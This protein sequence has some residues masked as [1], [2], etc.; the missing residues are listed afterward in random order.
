MDPRNSI[1]ASDVFQFQSLSSTAY[2]RSAL[3]KMVGGTFLNYP[4]CVDAVIESSIENTISPYHILSRILQE[5]G[6]SGSTLSSG[7]GYMVNGELKYV[8][9][10]NVFNIGATGNTQKDI[11]INGLSRAEKEGWNSL[12][13]SIIGGSKFLGSNYID[14]GQNTLYFQKFNVVKTPYYSHQYMQNILAAQNE[15]VAMKNVYS[16]NGIINS[17]FDF[18]IP[19]YNGMPQVPVSRPLTSA[20]TYIG[21]I[22]SEIKSIKLDKNSKGTYLYGES[23]IVEWIDR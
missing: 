8:G 18:I 21:N 6:S 15:G 10:Y 4:N 17:K 1:N 22:N 16:S 13:K 12:V 11:I 7:K 23:V 2:S 3:E 9:Y 14:L 20:S 19:L 5:Q